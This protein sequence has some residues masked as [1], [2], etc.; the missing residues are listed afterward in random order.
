VELATEWV[1][2]DGPSGSLSAYLAHPQA[3]SGPL[4][5]VIVI[6][7]IWGVDEHIIDLTDRLA[8]AGYVALAPDLFSAPEGKRPPALSV[9]RMNLAKGFLNSL[10]P[11][12]WG[13]VMGDPARREEALSKLPDGEGAKVGE[14]IDQVWGGPVRDAE[15]NVAHL[16]AAFTWLRGHPATAGRAVA[17][18]GYCLGGGLSARLA[19][20]EP[21]LGAAAIY[22]G[23]APEPDQVRE[24][25]CPIRGFYGQNDPRIMDGLPG[26]EQALSEA[27]VDYELRVYPDA[28]HAFFNDGRPSYNAEPARDAWGRTLQFFADALDPVNTAPLAKAG[29]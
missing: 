12:E 21:E 24:I 18:I 15:A 23:G 17:S 2:Y 10:P 4:P 22:Y 7:E 11:A 19:C 5:G 27:G 6:Q 29:A 13:A 9:E 20:A 25:R 1:N 8:T 16:R 26:F 28:G 3:A 14:T